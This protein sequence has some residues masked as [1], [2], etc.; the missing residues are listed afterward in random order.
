MDRYCFG[1]E[2]LNAAHVSERPRPCEYCGAARVFELQ[3]L[4]YLMSRLDASSAQQSALDWA[5]VLVHTCGDSCTSSADP[6]RTEQVIVQ[7]DPDHA[8][9]P[10]TLGAVAKR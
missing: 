5:T 3:L 8:L 1:G 2:P 6:V 4:P 9:L 7:H 10:P